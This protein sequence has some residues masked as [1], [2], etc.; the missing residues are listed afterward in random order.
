MIIITQKGILIS[1][2]LFTSIGM[3]SYCS[4]SEVNRNDLSQNKLL[5]KTGDSIL[6]KQRFQPIENKRI[7]IWPRKEYL[8][9]VSELK[10][11]RTQYGFQYLLI[12][13]LKSDYNNA[14]EAGFNPLKIMVLFVNKNYLDSVKD[15]GAVY[16]DEP[17][18]KHYEKKRVDFAPSDIRN[19]KEK[20]SSFPNKTKI[21][22][23]TFK[24]GKGKNDNWEISKNFLEFY[25]PLAETIMYTDYFCRCGNSV[26]N[27]D[28]RPAWEEMKSIFGS[29]FSMV[30]ISA[31]LDTLEYSRLFDMA[32]DLGLNT[33]WLYQSQDNY[34]DFT[35]IESFSSKAANNG[36][37]HL[38]K[39]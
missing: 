18:L 3:L 2:L 33:I 12:R 36:W 15:I 26:P 14:I 24:R 11:L 23:G 25:A 7:G 32:N 35:H 20:I 29:K 16:F 37:L 8:S 22:M 21:I 5:S 17:D 31:N 28:Q 34:T 19:F 9:S 39:Y 13:P 4:R 30:W 1:F 38:I 10:K 6:A 27:E